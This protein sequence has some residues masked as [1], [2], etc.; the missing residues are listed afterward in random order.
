MNLVQA[1]VVS[2]PLAVQKF[3]GLQN[4]TILGFQKLSESPGET[5]DRGFHLVHEVSS[6][7]SPDYLSFKVTEL[8]VHEDPFSS[9]SSI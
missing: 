7:V 5:N 6:R 4:E 3:L 1:S 2:F 9:T 8:C